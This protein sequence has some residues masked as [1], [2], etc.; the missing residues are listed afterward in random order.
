M[1]PERRVPPCGS[2]P[3]R[4]SD[5][6]H[7]SFRFAGARTSGFPPL[8]TLREGGWVEARPTS[9]RLAAPDQSFRC[10]GFFFRP[11]EPQAF[12]ASFPGDRNYLRGTVPD[13]SGDDRHIL[14]PAAAWD[15]GPLGDRDYPC[16]GAEPV[17]GRAAIRSLPFL[18]SPAPLSRGRRGD[19]YGGSRALRPSVRGYRQ[20]SGRKPR[21][22]ATRRHFLVP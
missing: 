13:G 22:A 15:P 9:F 10:L 21:P 11:A 19:R 7:R 3:W 5:R 20:T 8:E 16:P 4:D 14:D 2:R 12:D 6:E 17:R 1:L 18:A